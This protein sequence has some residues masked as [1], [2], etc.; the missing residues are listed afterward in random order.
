[1]KPVSYQKFTQNLVNG[2]L[3]YSFECP[4]DLILHSVGIKINASVSETITVNDVA[5]VADGSNYDVVL[6]STTLSSQQNYIFRPADGHYFKKGDTVKVTCT[7]AAETGV[8]Y[9]RLKYTEIG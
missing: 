5:S 6:D 3:V 1:M 4:H 2:A 8:L 7:N 9:G